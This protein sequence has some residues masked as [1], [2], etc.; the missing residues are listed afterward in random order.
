MVL[1]KGQYSAFIW[2]RYLKQCDHLTIVG[3]NG[4]VANHKETGINISSREHVSFQLFDNHNSIRGLISGRQKIKRDIAQLVARHDIVILRGISE[5]GSIAYTEAKK[6]GKFIVMEVVSC[7][8]DE[9]WYHGSI[10]A[11]FYAFYRYYKQRKQAKSADA[12]FYVS[13]DFLQKRYPSVAPIIASVSDV[14]IEKCNINKRQSPLKTP[15]VIGMIGTLKNKLKGVHI[16]IKACAILK[17][18][19]IHDFELRIL[20]PGNKEPWQSIIDEQGLSDHVILDGIR[21][22]GDP[23]FQWLNDL[24][25]YIQPSFQEGLPRAVV[26]AMSQSLPVIGSDAGGIPELIDNQW[27]F[28]RGRADKLAKHIENMLH[29]SNE[30]LMQIHDNLVSIRDDF[31]DNVTAQTQKNILNTKGR[32]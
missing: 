18:K 31:W 14:V 8:W 15:I 11:K 16:A 21:Q 1:S 7:A 2:D 17:S 28:K 20:G 19:G 4:G 24:D 25:I 29:L 32:H 5:L 6:Q 10:A 3:R 9:L 30:N 12:C 22:S 26:E 13:Q 23:V 27:V